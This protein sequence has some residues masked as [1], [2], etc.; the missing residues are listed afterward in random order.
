MVV[1]LA[2]T[3]VRVWVLSLLLCLA[4]SPA[5]GDG[6]ERFRIHG[7]IQWI[8][9]DAMQLQTDGGPSISLDLSQVDQSS[10]QGLSNGTGVTVTGVVVRPQSSGQGTNL[11]AESIIADP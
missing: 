2:Q 3:W 8:A 5:P 11:V 10:Y 6:Q 9:G 1:G 7:Y 4:I